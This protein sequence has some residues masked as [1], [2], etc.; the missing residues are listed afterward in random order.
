[1]SAPLTNAAVA[2]CLAGRKLLEHPFYRR[3]DAGEVPPSELSAL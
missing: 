2:S 1:M 3:W